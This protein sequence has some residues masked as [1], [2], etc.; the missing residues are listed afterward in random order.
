MRTAF[1][2]PALSQPVPGIRS[3]ELAN[4]FAT[5]FHANSS[6]EIQCI[7]ETSVRHLKKA[8]PQIWQITST[9]CVTSLTYSNQRCANKRC[10]IVSK[11]GATCHD[12]EFEFAA[13]A[14]DDDDNSIDCVSA[15][16]Q[17]VRANRDGCT[18]RCS[19][20][21]TYRLIHRRMTTGCHFP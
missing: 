17:S 5:N 7:I 18:W 21:R 19:S 1:F 12:T 16:R 14:A 4:R 9:Q 6:P 11:S 3:H 2:G 20:I 13:A 8:G 15:M 10:V